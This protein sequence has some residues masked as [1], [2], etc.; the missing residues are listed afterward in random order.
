MPRCPKASVNRFL[1]EKIG[2][3]RS[4]TGAPDVILHDEY[5]LPACSRQ[6]LHRL[7]NS[8][9]T[10][11]FEGASRRHAHRP[12]LRAGFSTRNRV[13]SLP[14]RSSV[15][16]RR[17]RQWR[18]LGRGSTAAAAAVATPCR[19]RK[20]NR[21]AVDCR[22]AAPR[23]EMTQPLILVTDCRAAPSWQSPGRLHFS[24]FRAAASSFS[25]MKRASPSFQTIAYIFLSLQPRTQFLAAQPSDSGS[26]RVV[27]EYSI[28]RRFG[29][30]PVALEIDIEKQP[31][32]TTDGAAT[33]LR[34]KRAF[35]SIRVRRR[36]GRLQLIR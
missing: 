18:K 4:S 8:R 11:I 33:P 34:L 14:R 5:R 17:A 15:T 3:H 16:R 19:R 25:P 9:G 30:F 35:V 21:D 22:P 36:V 20:R 7:D 1:N 12:Q 2:L 29:L 10:S 26:R 28:F 27:R 13:T 31:A 6:S 23:S 24:E 32:V